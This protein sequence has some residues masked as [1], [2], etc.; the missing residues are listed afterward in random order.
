M[1]LDGVTSYYRRKDEDDKLD[2]RPK[3]Y[4]QSFAEAELH[5][6]VAGKAG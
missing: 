2:A 5:A 3:T 4:A 6:S 1:E